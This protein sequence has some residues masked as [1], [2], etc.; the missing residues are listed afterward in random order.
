MKTALRIILAI[1]CLWIVSSTLPAFPQDAYK[2]ELM[3]GSQG[4]GDGQFINPVGVAVD[5]SGNVYVAEADT[6]RIQKF[7]SSG[8]FISKLDLRIT[9]NPPSHYY[10]LGVATDSIGNLYAV[11][12]MET[13][14]FITGP[15]PVPFVYKFDSDGNF[16]TRWGD[17]GTGD[18]QFSAPRGVA[19]DWL[20]NVYVAD[21]GNNRIQKFD[22]NGNFITKWGSAG[23]EDGQFSLPN[24]VA[25]DP[26]GNVYVA[27]TWNDRIQK[28]D[29][30]GNFITKWVFPSDYNHPNGVAVDP[31][32]NVYV[33]LSQSNPPFIEFPPE[34][35][36]VEQYDSN[37]NFITRWGSHGEE[38]GQFSYPNG[39]A[40]DLS[41]NVYVADTYNQRIQKF[42]LTLPPITLKSPLPNVHFDACSSYSPPTF[43]WDVSETFNAYRVEFSPDRNF[44]SIPNQLTVQSPATEITVPSDTWEEITMIPGASG[45]TIYWRVVGTRPDDTTETSGVRS[46]VIGAEPAGNPIIS[47]TVKRSKPTLTWQSYCNTKFKLWFGNDSTFSNRTYSFGFENPYGIGGTISKTLTLPQ[48]IRIKLLARNKTNS[49]LYWYVES[50]DALGRYAK[51]DVMSFMLTD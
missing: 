7:D 45:G 20:G 40:A 6:D 43:S 18:A 3:W 50:W 41:G 42:S 26:S 32:G 24:G 51:T 1:V 31:L 34:N 21:T 44:T 16:V 46:L 48:W 47:P 38:E 19:A 29:S 23:S 2:L 13:T 14:T 10:S 37:G 4:T 17:R 12:Y 30:N 5:S 27:D 9:A 22:P 8:N 49:T 11:V 33:V 25:V 35:P 36:R 15:P 28:F 39:L